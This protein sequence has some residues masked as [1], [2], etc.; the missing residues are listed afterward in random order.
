MRS[1][2]NEELCRRRGRE[3]R[4]EC[5][6]VEIVKV[7]VMHCPAYASIRSAFMLKL[8]RELGDRFEHF[9]KLYS[10]GSHLCVSSTKIAIA[11]QRTPATVVFF[12][13]LCSKVGISHLCDGS[14]LSSG[15]VVKGMAAY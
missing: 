1:G 5:F 4:K 14:A 2:L 12:L 11:S 9:C 8:R 6:C 7:L 15:C 10:F 3:G 13:C